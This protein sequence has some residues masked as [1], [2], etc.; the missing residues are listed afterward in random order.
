MENALLETGKLRMRPI[1]I[2]ALAL[3]GAILP[4]ALWSGAGDGIMQDMAW[5]IIGGMISATVLILLL[6]PVLYMVI[7]GNSEEDEEEELPEIEEV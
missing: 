2:T 3:I 6:F 5:V 1:L 7:Y 4:M